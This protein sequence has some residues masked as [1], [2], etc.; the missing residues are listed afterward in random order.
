[1]NPSNLVQRRKKNAEERQRS[2]SPSN[3]KLCGPLTPRDRFNDA[4]EKFLSLERERQ[5]EQEKHEKMQISIERK[6]QIEPPISPSVIPLV[7]SHPARNWSRSRDSDDEDDDFRYNEPVIRRESSCQK[8]N[9]RDSIDSGEYPARHHAKSNAYLSKKDDSRR[10]VHPSPSRH[11]AS[12]D[13]NNR[14]VHRRYPSPR[15]EQSP[16]RNERFDS[17]VHVNP[18]PAPRSYPEDCSPDDMSA[19]FRGKFQRGHVPQVPFTDDNIAIPLERYRSPTRVTAVPRPAPRHQR[20]STP[21]SED[22]EEQLEYR[23]L[24]RSESRHYPP[25]PHFE[26]NEKKRRSMYEAIED[27]RRKNSNELAKEFKCRS[28]QEHSAGYQELEDHE[29]YPGLDRETA[30]IYNKGDRHSYAEPFLHHQQV[31]PHHHELLHRTN[32]SVSSGRV[33]IAAIHPY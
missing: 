2:P 11:N 33:G 4:K 30:R 7:R 27:E 19:R 8:T 15:R 16:G 10:N 20:Y 18:R 31:L 1:M 25:R 32:S 17:P 5:E 14:P 26:N 22:E 24:N 6:R 12:E 23:H 21:N 29:R 13:R 28:Y 9:S 3:V